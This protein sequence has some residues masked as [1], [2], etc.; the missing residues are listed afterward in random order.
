MPSV[1]PATAENAR[2]VRRI[3]FACLLGILAILAFAPMVQV[4]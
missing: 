2:W 1:E 3:V 4:Q